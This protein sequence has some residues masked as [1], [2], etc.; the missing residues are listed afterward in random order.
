MFLYGYKAFLEAKNSSSGILSK[1]IYSKKCCSVSAPP[2]QLPEFNK[3]PCFLFF[4]SL[5]VEVIYMPWQLQKDMCQDM[6]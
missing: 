6:W 3:E 1:I 5:I 2:E 4:H